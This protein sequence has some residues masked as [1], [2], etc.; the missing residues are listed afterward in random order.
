[1]RRFC[2]VRIGTV[3]IWLTMFHIATAHDIAPAAARPAATK[4]VKARVDCMCG[5]GEL[6]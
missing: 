4:A 5:S 3:L 2:P 1:M 6:S